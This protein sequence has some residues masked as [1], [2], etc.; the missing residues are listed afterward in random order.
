MR[1][2]GVVAINFGGYACKQCGVVADVDVKLM[3]TD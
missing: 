2:L 3:I 1:V